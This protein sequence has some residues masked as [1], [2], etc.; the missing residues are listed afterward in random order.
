MV[1][2]KKEKQQLEKYLNR[3]EAAEQWRDRTYRDRWER[4]YKQ[5]RNVIDQLYDPKTKKPIKDRS[6][7]SI[8]Y[9]FTMLETILPR[10]V[11]TLFAG[12]PYVTVK[13]VPLDFKTYQ[14]YRD[15][16]P[17]DDSAQKMEVLLDY[18]QNV[19]FD[20]Q[21]T[22]HI[23]LKI[24]GLYGTTV[25]YT[26][27]RYKER[28]VVRK[29]LKQVFDEDPET[30]EKVPMMEDDGMT[31]VT[32]WEPVTVSLKEYDDPEVRFID[33]GLFYVDPN[34][35]DIDDARYAGHVCYHSKEYIDE[36]ADYEGIKINWKKVPK[37]SVTNEARNRRMS[38]IGLPSIDESDIN[39]D[40]DD[41]NLFEVHYYW[42]D[43]KRVMIINRG[44]LA[45][46]TANPFWHKRK[47]YDKDVYTKV[48]GEFHGIGI[49]EML[50][51]LQAELN[52]ERNQ[53]IDYRSYSLRRMFKVRRGAEINPA[54]LVW[55]Q[56]G[57]IEVD[58]L[59]DLDIIDTP[60]ISSD[61]FNQEQVIK[62]DMRDATGAH[63]V[64][65]GTSTSSETAT[66]TMSKDNNASMRFKLII[67]SIEK[68][69]LVSISRKM[70]Q[71]NQQFIDD[72][73]LLPNFE[74]PDDPWPEISPE[75]IQGEFHLTAAGSSVEPLANKEAFKQRM[76]ELYGIAANDP[77]YQQYPHKRRALL[78]KVFEAFDITDVDELLPTEDEINGALE[79]QVIG[80]FLQSLPPE[81]Q[82]LLGQFL[83]PQAPMMPPD[84]ASTPPDAGLSGGGANTA[85]MQE[86][87][88]QMVGG[89]A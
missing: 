9:S 86:Q 37:E 46:D 33:L 84:P 13:G 24:A 44:Y 15:M 87:G 11:E 64:V 23:G 63:D 59:D 51:D 7:I 43:D 8:P 6:N 32:D 58:D 12:R 36:I 5:Y 10:L 41:D 65:M 61:T 1:V 52:T 4:Y 71:L 88:L 28:E 26:G 40:H 76:I 79:Q 56:G 50:E 77:I 34:A 47:P 27:W 55:R 16:K 25:A 66:T 60:N 68:R 29:E 69:L 85:A 20:I 74:K 70:I 39:D 73:R 72:V 75:E 81:L 49:M 42:E 57:K 48:P 14:M 45:M 2:S 53:R 19:V 38:A 31:P 3:I 80:Q 54:E 22:F 35:E 17:W 83:A 82:Q 67:S 18:Q 30:G 78:K 89:L 62:G 21:D